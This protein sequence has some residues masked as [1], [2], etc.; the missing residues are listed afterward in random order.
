M[1]AITA[2]ISYA[3]AIAVYKLIPLALRIPS[4]TQLENEIHERKVA[5]RKLESLYDRS[6][7]TNRVTREIRKNL[8]LEVLCQATVE[9]CSRLFQADEGS[10]YIC[11]KKGSTVG[12]FSDT[13]SDDNDDADGSE[14]PYVY[15]VLASYPVK[16]PRRRLHEKQSGN[17]THE[18]PPFHLLPG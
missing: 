6:I 8:Q 15:T 4:T 9:E 1:K 14:V 7:V 18:F 2:I 5:Q 16:T 13:D 17:S 10:M 12:E 11:K 3:T